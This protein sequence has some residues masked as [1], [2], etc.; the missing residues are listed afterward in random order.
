MYIIIQ[1]VPYVDCSVKPHRANNVDLNKCLEMSMF[2]SIKGS[3]AKRV[4]T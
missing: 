3:E 1:F 2:L 4:V